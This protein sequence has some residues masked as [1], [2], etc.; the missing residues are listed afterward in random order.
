MSGEQPGDATTGAPAATTAGAPAAGRGPVTGF[1]PD[2]VTI[3]PRIQLIC[4]WVSA[5]V[6]VVLFAV[7]AWLLPETDTGVY[8]QVADQVS[9]VV[10]GLLIGGGLL[11]MAR[12]RVRADAA[13]VEVRNVGSA[14]YYPWS[15]IE[16]VAFP[17]GA[18]WAR[19][20]L[21]DDEYQPVLAVQSVDRD[22]AVRDIRRLRAL[23]QAQE[24]GPEQRGG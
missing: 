21:P 10:L 20:D 24:T 9:M 6:V 11:L 22:R 7:V 3:R 14:R 23:Y 4:A 19:L 2:T 15:E 1:G 18:S 5:A 12:P 17:D 8:F 13:G 16:G